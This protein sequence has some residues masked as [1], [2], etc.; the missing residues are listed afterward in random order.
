M[1]DDVGYELQHTN[2][3]YNFCSGKDL[4]LLKELNALAVASQGIFQFF[5]F[6]SLLLNK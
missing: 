1:L 2:Y 6:I 3:L 5:F 4:M